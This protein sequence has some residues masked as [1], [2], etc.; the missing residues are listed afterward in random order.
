VLTE[1]LRRFTMRPALRIREPVWR[2]GVVLIPMF[3]GRVVL[4]PR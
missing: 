4:T 2:R 3:G 1:L